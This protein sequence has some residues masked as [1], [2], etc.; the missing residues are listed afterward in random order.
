M[1]S[2]GF[3]SLRRMCWQAGRILEA[4]FYSQKDIVS[5]VDST[6]AVAVTYS[7]DAWGKLLDV[8]GTKLIKL[9]SFGV[10]SSQNPFIGKVFEKEGILMLKG[11]FIPTIPMRIVCCIKIGIGWLGGLLSCIN[12]FSLGVLLIVILVLCERTFIGMYYL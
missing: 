6:G 3:H 10:F 4:P 1:G 8:S 12:N 9:G 11:A 2:L 5:L 7:Y